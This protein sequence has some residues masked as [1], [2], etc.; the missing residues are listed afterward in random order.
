M[1]FEQAKQKVAE[2]KG[3]KDWELLAMMKMPKSLGICFAEA[4][5][6]M[7]QSNLEQIEAQKKEIERLNEVCA[8]QSKTYLQSNVD[9]L[10]R[11]KEL[12]KGLKSALESFECMEQEVFGT[13]SN[14]CVAE[15]VSIKQIL[16]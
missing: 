2:S 9:H 14:L 1:N 3:Y 6:L 13:L 8:N 5:E 15:I 11:I 16:K 7:N 4:A 12:E 10:E